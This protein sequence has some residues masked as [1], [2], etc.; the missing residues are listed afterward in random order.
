MLGTSGVIVAL[1]G[2]VNRVRIWVFK[3]C[4]SRG[5]VNISSRVQVRQKSRKIISPGTRLRCRRSQMRWNMAL[6]MHCRSSCEA[7]QAGDCSRHLA[8]AYLTDDCRN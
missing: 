2:Y 1:H 7:K 5:R 6:C 3:S 8:V 4:R